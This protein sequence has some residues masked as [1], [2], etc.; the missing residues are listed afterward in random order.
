MPQKK[1]AGLIPVVLLTIFQ[2]MCLISL[3][4]SYRMSNRHKFKTN[5][6]QCF[7]C[8]TSSYSFKMTDIYTLY[9]IFEFDSNNYRQCYLLHNFIEF[10]S[11]ILCDKPDIQD[12]DITHNKKESYRHKEQVQFECTN[13]KGKHFTVTCKGGNWIDIQSC[14]GKNVQLRQIHSFV[15]LV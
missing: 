11:E 6:Y 5:N 4:H 3:F 10:V 2:W 12:A 13:V 8:K 1:C 9:E 7:E 15:T 14:A